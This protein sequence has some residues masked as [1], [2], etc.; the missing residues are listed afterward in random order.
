MEM[1]PTQFLATVCEESAANQA[2]DVTRPPG[3]HSAFAL[4]HGVPGGPAS[5]RNR[6]ANRSISYVRLV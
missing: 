4:R 6:S 2:L 5:Q 3:R 1:E